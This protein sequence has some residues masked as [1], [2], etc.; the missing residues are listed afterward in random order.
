ML[1]LNNCDSNY[2]IFVKQ[3]GSNTRTFC[4]D[5]FKMR[6]TFLDKASSKPQKYLINSQECKGVK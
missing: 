2:D 3:H 5:G 4:Q 6:E 1:S